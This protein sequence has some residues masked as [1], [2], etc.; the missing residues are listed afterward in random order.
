VAL[1]GSALLDRRCRLTIANP[2]ATPADF[3]HTLTD[4]IEIDGGTTDQADVPGMRVVFKI[5]KTDKKEPNTSEI[6]VYNLSPTR[7]ASLQK[8][9]V[10]VLLEAGYKETGITRYASADVRTVDHV[11][12][13]ADW[14]T[15][16][17]LGDGERAWKFARVYESWAPGTRV[18]D[19]LKR[20]ASAMGIETGNVDAQANALG[21][22]LDQGYAV[23]G[24]AARGL[25]QFVR[26]L[27]KVWSVQDGQLQI[28]DPY[29]AVDLPIPE[30]TPQTGL[31]GSPEMGSPPTKGKPALLKFKSLLVPTKPGAKVKLKSERYDG[32]VLVHKCSFEGDT[33]GGDWYTSIEGTIIK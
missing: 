32:F 15:T 4:V 14:V 5:D 10:K 30:I 24:S 28:L 18:A 29:A 2:V 9:G 8:I 31:V 21:A 11:R 1:S 6:K 26:S 27:G 22:R 23:A 17:K 25:D 20:L 3:A 12:E 7:R 13:G 16:L 19:V 33:H